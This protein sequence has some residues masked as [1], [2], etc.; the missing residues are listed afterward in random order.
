MIDAVVFALA[1]ARR[2]DR[3]DLVGAGDRLGVDHHRARV[4]LPKKTIWP[5]PSGF[6]VQ[7]W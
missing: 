7:R 1:V 4:L 5:V 3:H 2:E 6:I